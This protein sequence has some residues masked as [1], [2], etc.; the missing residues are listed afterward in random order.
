MDFA[1][2]VRI[3]DIQWQPN[4]WTP[5]TTVRVQETVY[6]ARPKVPG[7]GREYI[8]RIISGP[9]IPPTI[10]FSNSPNPWSLIQAVE[11][12]E[13]IRVQNPEISKCL[14]DGF[15]K[16]ESYRLKRLGMWK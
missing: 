16:K 13:G 10:V 8:V 7:T 12:N 9:G 1:K 5:F 6:G 15:V 3:R 14:P 11:F 4:S 2:T